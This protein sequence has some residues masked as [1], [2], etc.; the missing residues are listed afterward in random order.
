MIAE[1]RQLKKSKDSWEEKKQQQDMIRDFSK[2]SGSW[3]LEHVLRTMSETVEG[4][5]PGLQRW[6]TPAC[7]CF[8]LRR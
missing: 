5:V 4:I 3:C 2:R 1:A 7:I 8:W 6:T